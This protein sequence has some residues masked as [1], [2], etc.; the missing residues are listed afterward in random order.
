MPHD[1][2]S[3][4][5]ADDPPRRS[6]KPSTI[7]VAVIAAVMVVGVIAVNASTGPRKGNGTL[8]KAYGGEA[9]ACTSAVIPM[10]PAEGVDLDRDGAKLLES[11]NGMQGIGT[12]TIHTDDP[13]AEVQFCD[14]STSEEAIRAAMSQTGLVTFQ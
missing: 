4:V 6:V 8:T 3:A 10:K 5:P 14:S 7:I 13:R 11:L 2:P 9:S 1:N 12:V